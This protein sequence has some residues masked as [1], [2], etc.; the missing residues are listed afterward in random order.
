M[1]SG[2]NVF[3]FLF[4]QF[5]IHHDLK[6]EAGRKSLKLF[7]LIM[8]SGKIDIVNRKDTNF[9]VIEVEGSTRIVFDFFEFFCE[10][11]KLEQWNEMKRFKNCQ[12]SKRLSDVFILND[13]FGLQFINPLFNYLNEKE[14]KIWTNETSNVRLSYIDWLK[15]LLLSRFSEH[16]WKMRRQ[17]KRTI[18]MML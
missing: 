9:V 17:R 16:H 5:W 4:T 14:K 3:D 15:V 6:L 1:H 8:H 18:F 12:E 11:L 7:L 10:K 13:R 2:S